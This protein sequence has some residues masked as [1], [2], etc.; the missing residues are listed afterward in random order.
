M[1]L[2]RGFASDNNAGIHPAV[3]QAITTA[4]EGHC[5]GYGDDPFT[6]AAY[7]EFKEYFGEEVQVFFVFNGTGANVLA[8]RS[9]AQ[10]YH[11]I[12][13]SQLSH[14]N[15]DEC[16]APEN[17][18][19]CKIETLPSTNGKIRPEQIERFLEYHG[20]EHHAQ[21]RVISITQSTELGTVYRVEEIKALADFSHRN[22]MLLH[23]DGARLSNAA[24]FLDCSLRAVSGDAGVD[25]LSFGG[26]KIGLMLGEAVIFFRP[27]LAEGFKY[28]RKQGMHLGS[29]MRFIS[30][31]FTALL[32]EGLWL[33]NA[34]H[35]NRMARYLAQRLKSERGVRIVQKV[36]ANA[37]FAKIPG[38]I[39]EEL[40][41]RF[42]FYLWDS[43]EMVARFMTAF[44][45]TEEDVEGLVACIRELTS[46]LPDP[47]R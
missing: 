10:S 15:V 40:K 11:S 8:L 28:I 34:R 4:N 13:C 47:G 37:V 35:A 9:M 41:G 17:F 7:Q 31:Q 20:V 2:N 36:E 6:A 22:G 21:P 24:A 26:T 43:R 12:I 18:T 29:K 14:L 23:M 42:F 33:Q 16:G 38:D 25:V 46:D 44:D 5:I 30:T 3:L 1:P 39:V 27:E 32:R 45:T 19:G